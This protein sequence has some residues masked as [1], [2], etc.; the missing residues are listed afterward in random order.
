MLRDVVT[1]RLEPTGL[2]AELTEEKIAVITKETADLLYGKVISRMIM[3][4]G[5]AFVTCAGFVSTADST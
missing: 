4:D 3:V 1:E 2:L 5:K